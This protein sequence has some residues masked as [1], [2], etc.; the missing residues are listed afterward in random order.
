VNEFSWI[1]QIEHHVSFAFIA[2]VCGLFLK[3][4]K[5]IIK[6]KE[7]LNSLWFNHCADT[8]LPYQPVENGTEPRVPEPRQEPEWREEPK[9]RT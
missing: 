5:L 2:A 3:N 8:R 7:R 4:H 1:A 6:I 9:W